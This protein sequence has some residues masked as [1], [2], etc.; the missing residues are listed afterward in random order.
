MMNS[1]LGIGK[2]SENV[3]KKVL[4]N[5]WKWIKKK[6]KTLTDRIPSGD[7]ETIGKFVHL[8][9]WRKSKELI[10]SSNTRLKLY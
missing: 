1:A 8:W 6:W 9:I 5:G 7:I 2:M 3:R 4:I 10:D